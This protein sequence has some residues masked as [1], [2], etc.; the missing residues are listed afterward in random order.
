MSLPASRRPQKMALLVAQQIVTDIQTRGAGPGD[1]LP[2]EKQM[3]EEYQIGR[4]TLRESLR[5][6]ELQGLISLKPGP[7]GGPIVERPNGTGLATS[8][9]LLLQLEN[10]P[11]RDV[12]EARETIEPA[13]ARYAASRITDEELAA[14]KESVDRMSEHIKDE[15]IFAETNHEFH[16]VIAKASGNSL[17][18]HM[19]DALTGI[20]D[21]TTMGIEYPEHRRKHVVEA[22]RRIYEALA[23]RDAAAASNTM[24]E[25]IEEYSKYISRK[26]PD[27]IMEPI[28]WE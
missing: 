28:S 12:V 9:T 14:L 25:H 27:T 16:E 13:M 23:S 22:H 10:A 5:F 20:L 1:R 8:L 24:L 3:L 7:G 2:P 21:G 4:G 11:Y 15:E 6:L 19:I 17:F 18:T 26:Y